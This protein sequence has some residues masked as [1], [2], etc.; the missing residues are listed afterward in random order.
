MQRFGVSLSGPLRGSLGVFIPVAIIAL[1]AVI[2]IGYGEL[3]FLREEIRLDEARTVDSAAEFLQSRLGRI[4]IDAF[5]LS[6]TPAIRSFLDGDHFEAGELS[7]AL[8]AFLRENPEY[9]RVGLLAPAGVDLLRIE[10]GAHGV[11]AAPP[12]ADHALGAGFSDALQQAT[13]PVLIP[14]RQAYAAGPGGS[15]LG[16]RTVDFALP[17]RDQ[18]GRLQGAL[19]LD[20]LAATLRSRLKSIA[21]DSRGGLWLVDRNGHVLF[22]QDLP[23]SRTIAGTKREPPSLAALPPGLWSYINQPHAVSGM[24]HRSLVTSTHLC[25]DKTPCATGYGA[26][27]D[28]QFISPLNTPG[29]PW[30]LVTRVP[31]GVYGVLPVLL[32]RPAPALVLIAVDLLLLALAAWFAYL[33]FGSQRKVALR[34][35][36]LHET[37]ALLEAFVGKSPMPIFVKGQNGR[38]LY[39]NKAFEEH[40]VRTAGA[41]G[42]TDRDMPWHK[43]ADAHSEEDR[44]V[45]AQGKAHVYYETVTTLSGRRQM[46]ITK[47]P[48]TGRAYDGLTVGGFI[49]DINDLA[50]A[51]RITELNYQLLQS[52]VDAAPDAI[53]TIDRSGKVRTANRTAAQMFGYSSDEIINLPVEALVPVALR[54]RH[55][56]LRNTY[57]KAPIQRPLGQFSNLRGQRKDGSTFPVDISLDP[58]GYKDEGTVVAVVRDLSATKTLK[59]ASSPDRQLVPVGGLAG[60]LAHSYNNLLGIIVANLDLMKNH[61]AGD[62]T[63]RTRIGK[64]Q[65]AALRAAGLTRQL[66][67][68]AQQQ[69]LCPRRISLQRELQEMAA[70]LKQ[71]AG[72]NIEVIVQV[73][74]NCQ[75]VSIDPDGLQDAL[76]DVVT[77]AREAMVRGG[78]ITVSAEPVILTLE[79]LSDVTG[80]TAPGEYVRLS[81][82]DTGTGMPRDLVQRIPEPFYSTKDRALHRGLGLATVFGFMRQSGGNVHIVS[83]E[84]AGTVI[85]LYLPA[86]TADRPNNKKEFRAENPSDTGLQQKILFVDDEAELL[87]IGSEY[88]QKAGFTVLQATDCASALQIFESNPDVDLLITDVVIPGGMNGIELAAK[89]GE[90]KPDLPVLFVSGFPVPTS[91]DGSE[92]RLGGRL[93]SKPYRRE[94]LCRAVL[95]VLHRSPLQ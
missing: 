24:F 85:S 67:A 60:G 84:G 46:K 78:E 73:Q 52:I 95:D 64:A 25:R 33:L 89:F 66:L 43:W 50:E 37:G 8:R 7:A 91:L 65:H 86:A 10:R 59:N 47:F 81:V 56:R 31:A 9:A 88:L 3:R 22:S 29:L 28:V 68:L 77:N 94:D 63:A 58:I 48:I 34:D 14:D 19:E 55:A 72:A 76:R 30:I 20:L 87:E 82:T 38:Y 6:G 45:M 79:N 51:K 71:W 12:Q 11:H 32:S 4:A 36:M 74:P 18:R 54:E 15:L 41:V 53:L 70:R 26:H 23:G 13:G 21:E 92:L 49:T 69:A 40:F 39:V 2:A 83:N 80:H 44:S 61:L 35:Q 27:R 62:V 1:S 90:L 42:K 93:V 5:M 57:C 17:L 75:D 16:G